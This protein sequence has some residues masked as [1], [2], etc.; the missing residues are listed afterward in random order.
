MAV[1]S[2]LRFRIQA[3]EVS[4]RRSRSISAGPSTSTSVVS[5]S[6]I[7]GPHASTSSA[8]N[9]IGLLSSEGICL[10]TLDNLSSL[11][12]AHGRDHSCSRP[13]SRRQTESL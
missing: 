13:K 2:T 11:L 6:V 10:S 3:G 5:G 8:A 7:D 1:R 4:R 12:I 9:N